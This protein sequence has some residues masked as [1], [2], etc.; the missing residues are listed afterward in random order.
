MSAYILRRVLLALVT[1][2]IAATLVFLALRLTPQPTA[3]EQLAAQ[4]E[5]AK[6]ADCRQIFDREFGLDKPVHEQYSRFMTDLAQGDLGNSFTLGRQPVAG[7]IKKRIGTSIELG[8]L[9]VLTAIAVAVPVGVISAVR[10]DSWLDYVLRS[11]SLLWLAVPSFITA[12]FVLLS[13]SRWAGWTPIRPDYKDFFEDPIANLQT[14]IVP[15]L[16]GGLASG[17]VLMRFI[18]TELLEVLRQDYVRTAMSK[19][20]AERVVVMRHALRNAMIP[21]LT[22]M[23]FMIAGIVNGNF[24][25]ET[26]FVIPGVGTYAIQGLTTADYPVIQGVALVA[27]T[28]IIFSNLGVD[29]AYAWLDPRVT[30]R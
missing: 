11:F 2:W 10:Q 15:A 13:L 4:C 23:G 16:I 20:L 26:L 17:A 3:A 9:Q 12:V 29:L 7:E 27:A 1:I 14:M 8:L 18:R 22:V 6:M 24:I 25:L 28:A 30:Y 5:L 21:V 19:G